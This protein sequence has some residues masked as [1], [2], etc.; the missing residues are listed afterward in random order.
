MRQVSGKIYPNP[1]DYQM[2][3]ELD[4]APSSYSVQLFDMMGR[5]LVNYTNLSDDR[6]SIEQQG[7]G[8]GLYIL[9][10]NFKDRSYQPIVQKV[11]FN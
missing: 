5:E 9:R 4:E 8:A 6:V 7:W 11:R 1:A 2:T 10:I 3:I